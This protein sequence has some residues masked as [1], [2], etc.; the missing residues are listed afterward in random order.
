MEAL[1]Q[2][3][4]RSGNF[5]QH[6]LQTGSSALAVYLPIADLPVNIFLLLAL[7]LAVGFVSGMFGVGGG[8]LMTPLLIF[9]GVSPGI[10]VATVATH[11]TASSFSGMLSYWGRGAVDVPMAAVLFVGGLL[12]TLSG[13]WI[14]TTLRSVGQLDL[15]ISFSYLILL[16]AVGALMAME[17]LRSIMRVRQNKPS[18][19][20]RSGGAH[21]WVHG[22]PLKFR[23]RRSKIYISLIPLIGIG[24][25]I[26]VLGVMMGIGG[27][28]LLVPMLIYF[29]R[30]PTTTVIGTAA[31]LTTA[32]M[33]LTTVMHAV[34]NHLVDAI[35]ALVLMVGGVVGA[36]FGARSAQNLAPERL[37]FL[38]GLLILAVGFRFG[39][40]LINAPENPYTIRVLG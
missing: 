37:R 14:F 19:L 11:I 32:T 1:W 40:E 25:L 8:F 30:V 27:G 33:A 12:G 34:T 38:L 26:A 18:L 22:L 4:G 15:M 10:A 28:F 36:Q 24:Y 13:I 2:R 23:F 20:R 17:S 31:V 5:D 21:T 16:T 3:T 6:C 29:L 7:G 35:L 39:Y 9:L